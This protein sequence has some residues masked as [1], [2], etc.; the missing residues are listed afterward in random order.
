MN[1][2][3]EMYKSDNDHI[4]ILVTPRDKNELRQGKKMFQIPQTQIE[5]LFHLRQTEAAAY[6]VSHHIVQIDMFLTFSAT[7]DLSDGNESSLSTS[8]DLQ[9]AI[10]SH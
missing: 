5:S 6:L 3:T 7:G 8:W 2:D 10:F 9:V 1:Q 4:E